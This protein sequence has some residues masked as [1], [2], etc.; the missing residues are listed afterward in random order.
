MRRP[1]NIS[2]PTQIHTLVVST[3]F[4]KFINKETLAVL[5]YQTRNGHLTERIS[6]FVDYHLKLLVQTLPSYIKRHDPLSSPTPESRPAP[7]KRYWKEEAWNNQGFNGIWT[8]DLRDT[9][10]MLY[11]LSYKATYWVHISLV[12]SL[13]SPFFPPHIRAEPGR[14]KEESR[15]TCMHMLRT[16]PFLPLKSGGKPYLEVFSRFGLWCVFLNDNIQETISVFRRG[17]PTRNFDEISVRESLLVL[18]LS[19]NALTKSDWFL[20]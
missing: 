2:L 11:Q 20:N 9:G 13:N 4:Q 6:E 19:D 17:H 8:G 1:T 10:A 3:H 7:R 18:R 15:I 5:L 12:Q 16:P 14:A